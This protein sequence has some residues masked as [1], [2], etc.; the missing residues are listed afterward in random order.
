MKLL[1]LIG[2]LLMFLAH[3][4]LTLAGLALSIFLSFIA[5]LASAYMKS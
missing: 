3:V 5:I 2:S 1:K 4:A